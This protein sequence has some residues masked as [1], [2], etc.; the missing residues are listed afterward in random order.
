M[1]EEFD[2]EFQLDGGSI[3]PLDDIDEDASHEGSPNEGKP[4]KK[5]N[6]KQAAAGGDGQTGRAACDNCK[7]YH[8]RC[9]GDTPTCV[10]CSKRK[11]ACVYSPQKKRGPKSGQLKQLQDQVQLLNEVIR[12]QRLQLEAVDSNKPLGDALAEDPLAADPLADD[13]LAAYQQPLDSH[14]MYMPPPP[15]QQLQAADKKKRRRPATGPVVSVCDALAC[16]DVPVL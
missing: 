8:S 4:R 12:V 10:Q 1:S 3:S 5:K 6:T 16:V 15:P 7:K 9:S 11:I 13:P 14:D 2:S